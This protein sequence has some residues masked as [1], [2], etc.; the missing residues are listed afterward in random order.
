LTSELGSLTSELGHNVFSHKTYK[1]DKD[2]KRNIVYTQLT[3][4]YNQYSIDEIN[5]MIKNIILIK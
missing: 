5:C 3:T 4:T 2:N 1:T